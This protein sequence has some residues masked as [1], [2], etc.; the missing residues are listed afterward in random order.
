MGILVSPSCAEYFFYIP[1]YMDPVNMHQF[2]CKHVI[3]LEWKTSQ[4]PIIWLHHK[5]AVLGL[6]C[7]Q[8]WII[9]GSA[10]PGLFYERKHYKPSK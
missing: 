10:G 9:A 1:L 2:I 7:F 3:Q 4:I 6:H 8:I 5:P